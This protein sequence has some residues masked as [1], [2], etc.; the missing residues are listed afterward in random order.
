MVVNRRFKFN[1]GTFVGSVVEGVPGAEVYAS[2]GQPRTNLGHLLVPP[3][4]DDRSFFIMTQ[5]EIA[6]LVTGLGAVIGAGCP[7]GVGEPF[8]GLERS[9]AI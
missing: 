4:D 1:A 9:G 6:P 5:A 3:A 2:V 7:A 8:G